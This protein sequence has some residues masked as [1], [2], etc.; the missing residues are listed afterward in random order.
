[1]AC[2]DE[3]ATSSHIL[4]LCLALQDR[5]ENVEREVESLKDENLALKLALEENKSVASAPRN[6]DSPW[7]VVSSSA[8]SCKLQRQPVNTSNQFIT[9][10]DE[11]DEVQVIASDARSASSG[12]QDARKEGKV[13]PNKGKCKFINVVGDSMVRYL[14]QNLSTKVR[15]LE[16]LPGAGIGRVCE[17]LENVID[18][19]GD[20]PTVVLSAGSN[21]VG[22]LTSVELRKLY[23]EA[24]DKIRKKGGT[25]IAC[26]ILPRRGVRRE[27]LSRAI[28]FNC[29][30]EKL[31][32]E[33]TVPFIDNWSLYYGNDSMYARD[34][35]HLSRKGVGMLG[36]LVDRV[37]EVGF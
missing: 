12:E 19:F 8:T 6:R 14:G 4:Q 9:L 3:I 21:D 20:K 5:L 29:W 22:K 30:L 31:C 15:K 33:L 24:L 17:R 27:W 35:V 37:V 28:G 34:G 23:R 36:R 10:S 16:C 7:K 25:P 26:S 1:M 32:K 18:D 2:V 11:C 13:T